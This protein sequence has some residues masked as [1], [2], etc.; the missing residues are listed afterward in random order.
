ME[1]EPQAGSHPLKAFLTSRHWRGYPYL[2]S[3][4]ADFLM[5]GG[6]AVL[7]FIALFFIALPN[8]PQYDARHAQILAIATFLAFLV[9][10]PH[11]IV[12]YQLLYR[13]Y[14][15]KLA[16]FKTNPGL[17]ARYLIAGI[18]APLFMLGYFIYALATQN[19]PLIGYSIN[20][21]LVLVGWHYAKQSFGVFMMLSSLKRIF[22]TPL[23]RRLLLLNA[24][25]VW[26][27]YCLANLSGTKAIAKN[28]W[29]IDY[30]PMHYHAPHT[31]K[32]ASETIFITSFFIALITVTWEK[33]RISYTATL[34]YLSM[35][36]FLFAAA[37]HP[38]WIVV[39]PFFH[40]MQ[41]LLFVYA[42]KRGEKR[43]G[44]ASAKQLLTFTAV[45]VALG[46]AAFKFAPEALEAALNPAHSLVLPITACVIIFINIHHYFIDNVIWRKEH[47][48][49]ARYLFGGHP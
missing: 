29:D 39:Y 37:L 47:S 16:R 31:L 26:L 8:S 38:L 2:I 24:Y 45:A 28:L 18:L 35:Y 25:A 6:L 20:A 9:N 44:H 36:P 41:Y 3:P 4:L 42:Y 32:L 13:H 1:S 10:D 43:S 14:P 12:S 48:E 34:G 22:Y 19:A 7:M 40:S 33:K 21:M 15:A 11:F 49:I 23:Q 30:A 46:A 17:Y 5:V 27:T